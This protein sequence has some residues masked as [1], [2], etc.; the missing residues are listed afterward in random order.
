MLRD[1]D[2]F[3]SDLDINAD[4]WHSQE[5]KEF[6]S[7]ITQ[8]KIETDLDRKLLL[9]VLVRDYHLNHGSA[10]LPEPRSTVDR[11]LASST[12]IQIQDISIYENSQDHVQLTRM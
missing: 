9:G 6:T 2:S 1:E 11:H 10:R 8:Y 5:V 4:I 3:D 7:Q 12:D